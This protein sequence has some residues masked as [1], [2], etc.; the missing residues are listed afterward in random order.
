MP[1]ST[2]RVSTFD[3][4]IEV[5]YQ[6][7]DEFLKAMDSMST[8]SISLPPIHDAQQQEFSFFFK[9]LELSFDQLMETD[10]AFVA[11]CLAKISVVSST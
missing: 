6:K 3:L 8:S 10:L 1:K 11:L 5:I 9:L 2:F 4:D 7:V